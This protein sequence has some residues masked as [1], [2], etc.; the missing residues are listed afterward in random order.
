[1]FGTLI[2]VY[3]HRRLG[4]MELRNARRW[5]G[6]VH[7]TNVSDYRTA[8]LLIGEVRHH[9]AVISHCAWVVSPASR[10]P[11]KRSTPAEADDP[12]SARFGN[13]FTRRVEI[14][15]RLVPAPTL[16]AELGLAMAFHVVGEHQAPLSSIV[17]RRRNR[18]ITICGVKIAYC[19]KVIVDT[20]HFLRDH[21]PAFAIRFRPGHIGIQLMPVMSR[22]SDLHERLRV[23]YCSTGARRGAGWGISS[24]SVFC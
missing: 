14:I 15:K 16:V 20:V 7:V 1:M 24:A 23:T 11:G 5:Q 4:L 13:R 22:Y 3:R 17:E 19:P 6:R 9:A 18:E 21:Q 10:Q 8:R 12:H 2:D